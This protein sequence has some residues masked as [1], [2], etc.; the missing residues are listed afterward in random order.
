MGQDG[1]DSATCICWRK[2]P[3]A[4]TWLAPTWFCKL[5]CLQEHKQCGAGAC[6]RTESSAC[7][8]MI[9][10]F[11]ILQHTAHAELRE[12]PSPIELRHCDRLR[13][14]LI[15]A[16]RVSG[17]H[18]RGL[19]EGV[20]VGWVCSLCDRGV[21]HLLSTSRAHSRQNNAC[22]GLC[23]GLRAVFGP[24]GA[25]RVVNPKPFSLLQASRARLVCSSSEL[26]RLQ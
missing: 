5:Q 1:T 21:C 8:C 19:R 20:H 15:W 22:D 12:E 3:R 4:A 11:V 14:I 24:G 18:S 16:S 23:C 2:A 17:I 10:L 6:T 26:G 13:I 25:V 9:A 7:V